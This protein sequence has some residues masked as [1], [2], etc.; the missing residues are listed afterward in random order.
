MRSKLNNDSLETNE[1]REEE[2]SGKKTFKSTRFAGPEQQA[3]HTMQLVTKG[4]MN[5][6]AHWVNVPSCPAFALA[7]RPVVDAPCAAGCRRHP[8]P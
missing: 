3:F 8:D 5:D 2:E 4:G 7:H 6:S 1:K